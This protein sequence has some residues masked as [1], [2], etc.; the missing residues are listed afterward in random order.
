MEVIMSTRG[1]TNLEGIR[2]GKNQFSRLRTIVE[3]PFYGNNVVEIKTLAD[4]Y[5]LAAKSSGAILTSREIFEPEKIGLKKGSK[6]IIFNDGRTTGRTASARHI[7]YNNDAEDEELNKV[8]MDAVYE[9]RFK[10]ML[11][12]K[13]VV[14]L[15]EDF[16]V[17]AHLLIPEGEE[18]ILYNWLLNFQPI[19]DEIKKMYTNSKKYDEADIIVFSDPQWKDEKYPNGIAYFD[20]EN[21]TLALLGLK[22]FGEHKKGTLTLAWSIA[23]RNGFASCHGGIKTFTRDNQDPFTLAVFGLSGSGKSTITHY[24]HENKYDIKILHDDAFIINTKDKYSIAL[25]PSYFDKTQNYP[26]NSPGNKYLLS[27]QNVGATRDDNGN[28]VAVTEDIRNGNGRAIKSKLWSSNRVN[29]LDE[30]INAICWIMK[31]PV[32]PPIV[33]I[34][35]PIMASLLGASLVTKRSSAENLKKGYDFTKLVVEPYAN[36]FR[37]YPLADDYNK[38]LELFEDG[39]EC[40]IINSGDYFGKDIPTDITFTALEKIVDCK[41]EFSDL[42][43]LKD[44]SYIEIEGYELPN[45]D[46]YKEKLKNSFK[47]RLDYFDNLS[48]FNALP[49]SALEEFRKYFNSI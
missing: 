44:F 30:K 35:N 28:I 6:V 31:D 41:A 1:G 19:N 42:F 22:Y 39:V 20:S 24:K 13:S 18:N 48:E 16:S 46:I 45:Y 8:V 38:F 17:K 34:N 33:K 3:T 2:K 12:A 14:G 49:E 9:T 23:N 10:K 47:T 5:D 36:P 7:S 26:P 25:E 21:N 11:Y 37:T 4:A 43:N 32:F 40:Y 15:N 29:R 27:M